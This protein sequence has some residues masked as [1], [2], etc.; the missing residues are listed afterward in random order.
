MKTLLP[1]FLFSL[2]FAYMTEKTTTGQYMINKQRYDNKIYYFLLLLTLIL[3][4]GLRRIYNDTGAYINNF[5]NSPGVNEIWNSREMYI[6]SNPAFKLYN[7][8]IREV[9]DNYHVFLMIPAIFVQYSFVSTIRR[10][11]SS[12]T[13]GIGLY[14][15]LGTYVL[16]MAAMKQVIATGIVMLAIPSLM[17]RKW[18][19]YYLLIFIAFMFHTYS[20]AFVIL[21]LFLDKPWNFRTLLFL[22]SIIFIINNFESVIGSFLEYANDSGKY[23]AEYEIFDNAQ[24]NIFRVMVYAVVPIMALLLYAYLF[25]GSYPEH[26]NVFINMSI[27]SCAVMSIGT[28]NGAN[29]FGRMANYFEMGT[30]CSMPWIIHRAFT[31]RSARVIYLIATLCFL[32]YFYYAYEIALDFDAEYRAVT[33]WEFIQ[34]LF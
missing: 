26:Y 16:T 23:V 1:I 2:F 9:T 30:I 12:F 6:L 13:L 18:T 28:V 4:V 22:A 24:I 17:D 27:I 14:L 29:M 15:C 11:S 25:R 7:S 21:P 34:S 10:Y 8:V 3:P 5:L 31:R 19:K 33:I 32:F 20:I